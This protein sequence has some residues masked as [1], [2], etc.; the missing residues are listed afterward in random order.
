MGARL[1]VVSLGLWL[2]SLAPTMPIFAFQKH[3]PFNVAVPVQNVD[4]H[5]D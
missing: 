2:Q 5:F 1:R 4:E 3:R